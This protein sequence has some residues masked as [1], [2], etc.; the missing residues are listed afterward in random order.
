MIIILSLYDFY[1]YILGVFLMSD[2]I[3]CLKNL[4]DNSASKN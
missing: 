4:V 2:M 1:C 3:S